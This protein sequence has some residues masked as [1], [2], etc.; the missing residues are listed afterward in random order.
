VVRVER[1]QVEV[2][3]IR[4]EDPDSERSEDGDLEQAEDD[5][6]VR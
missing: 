2:A 3:E 5:A 4:E 6:C 1:L